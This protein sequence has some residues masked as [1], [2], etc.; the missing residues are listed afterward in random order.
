MLFVSL[1]FLLFLPI[2][3]VIY[4]ILSPKYR[5]LFLLVCSYF[6]YTYYNPFYL[7]IIIFSTIIDYTIGIKIEN[8]DLT[9]VKRRWLFISIFLNLGILCFFKYFNFFAEQINII[10]QFFNS[11]ST[12]SYHEFR[13]PLGISFYTFQTLSYTIDVYR[14]KIKAEKHIGKYALYVAFFPQLVAGPIERAKALLTQFHFKYKFDYQRILEGLQLII[15]GFF[16]KLII[17]D[18]LG[19]Y[20]NEVFNNSS[21]YT[22]ISIWIASVFFLIQVYCDFSGY[23]NIAVGIAKIFGINLSRNFSNSPY[24]TFYLST[25]FSTWHITLTNWIRD[26][27]YYP[28]VKKY[29]NTKVRGLILIFILSLS[30]LWHGANWTYISWGVIFGIYMAIEYHTDGWK[31]TLFELLKPWQ[32]KIIKGLI[33]FINVILFSIACLFFRASDMST[34]F[35]L[36]G[37]SVI[38][39]WNIIIIDS[40]DFY[41][42]IFFWFIMEVYHFFM[43]DK[44]I[45][46]YLR[47]KNIQIRWFFY[48]FIIN[49]II[50]FRVSEQI[51]FIYFEF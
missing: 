17:A 50:Y 36:I 39:N 28:L 30:G 21:D 32:A 29:K 49:C 4:F 15:W 44:M 27:I 38:W 51:S 33:I 40:Y 43:K 47:E 26:Y 14:G 12:L 31:Y 37:N 48:I 2:V 35:E 1:D 11:S 24:F 46:E 3:C 25:L 7:F 23:T 16:K 5:W 8:N 34:A 19:L 13:L 9:Q 22:G 18:R 20:V 42:G 10:L 45:N 41:L 6:F